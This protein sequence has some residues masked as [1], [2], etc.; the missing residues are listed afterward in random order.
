[1]ADNISS[2]VRFSQGYKEKVTDEELV[3]MIETGVMNSVGDFL[4]SSYGKG[5]TEGHIRVWNDA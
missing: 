1:M 5:K 3:S 4:N 2:V